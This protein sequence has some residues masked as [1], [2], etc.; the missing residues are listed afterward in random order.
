MMWEQVVP[1][2]KDKYRLIMVDL[3]GHGKSDVT[4]TGYHIDQLSSDVNGVMKYLNVR[5][6]HFIGS[7]LGAE[8]ALSLAANHPDKF[9]SLVLEG[10]LYSENGPYGHWEGTDSEFQQHVDDILEKT[11]NTPDETYSSLD[12]LVES[13]LIRFEITE[14][15]L[16]KSFDTA[17]RYGA[18]Q[19]DNGR[20]A[21]VWGKL[22]SEDYI[23]HYYHYRF[24]DYYKKIICPVLMLPDDESLNHKRVN[25]I[26]KQFRD[27]TPQGQILKLKGW[28]HASGWFMMSEKV[29]KNIVEFLIDV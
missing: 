16:V 17:V 18:H 2:F 22:Q 13:V 6:A 21:N 4:T 15:V 20:Y 28:Q 7:S 27:L 3:R 10:A 19:L 12:S 1:Y 11:R 8:V 25:S 9:S 26:M 14:P 5:Q 23:P 24:E 29:S